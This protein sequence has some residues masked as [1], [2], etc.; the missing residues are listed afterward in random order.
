VNLVGRIV[1]YCGIVCSDCPVFVATQ[2]ND[3]TERQTVA[4]TFTK[5]YGK[6]YKPEAINCD[7]CVTNGP[8]IFKY[9]SICKIRK[10]AQEKKVENCAFCSG[11]PC[12]MVSELHDAYSKA[13]N[14][15]DEIGCQRGLA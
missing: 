1:A 8:R 7:S 15:L 6:E 4:D 2:K 3:D 11:Y 10:C 5:Q 12:A 13:K 14:T 9:C